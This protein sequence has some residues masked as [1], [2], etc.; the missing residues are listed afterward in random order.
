MDGVDLSGYNPNDNIKYIKNDYV[1]YAI[2]LDKIDPN[3]QWKV[4]EIA[5]FIGIGGMGP[6]V[7]GSPEQVAD[8]MEQWIEEQT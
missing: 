1:R 4:Q 3:K 7:I 8:Q 2:E 5:K 6:V